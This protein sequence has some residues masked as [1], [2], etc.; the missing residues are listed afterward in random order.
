[1]QVALEVADDARL[2]T[3]AERVAKDRVDLIGIEDHA[4]LHGDPVEVLPRHQAARDWRTHQGGVAWVVTADDHVV[5]Y[6]SA[7]ITADATAE[8]FSVVAA[9]MQHRG[10]GREARRLALERFRQLG[11]QRAVSVSRPGS[12]SSAISRSLGY[13]PCGREVRTAPNGTEVELERWEK[14]IAAA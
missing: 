5:G 3:F 4:W 2:A 8:T 14:A 12:A 11:V 13:R 7:L 9:D 1:M 6:I 10:I